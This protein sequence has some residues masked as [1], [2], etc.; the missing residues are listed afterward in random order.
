MP[1]QIKLTDRVA[2]KLAQRAKEDNLSLAGE[3]DKL[4][5]VD[6]RPA[7]Y[8]DNFVFGKLEYLENYIDKKFS[9]LKSLIEDTTVDRVAGGR[10]PRE[11]KVYIE[12]DVARELFYEFLD[13]NS[14]EWRPG[15]FNE[16]QSLDNDLSCY[17]QDGYICVDDH[18]GKQHLLVQVSPRV[19][20]FLKKV[21][22]SI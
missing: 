2:E 11:E 7:E 13:E 14:T 21:E 8:S 20:E 16:I 1:K 6:V 17:I 15:V 5:S 3:V 10:A 9:E 18:Y 4:L 19:N 12:W 22:S